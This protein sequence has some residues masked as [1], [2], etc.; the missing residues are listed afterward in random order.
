MAGTSIDRS[1]S[2]AKNPSKKA[3][4]IYLDLRSQKSDHCG[5]RVKVNNSFLSD[6]TLNFKIY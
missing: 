1:L 6:L 2:A 3:Q 5:Q 4:H